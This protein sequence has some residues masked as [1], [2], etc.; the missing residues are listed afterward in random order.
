VRQRL[1]YID[2][3][4]AIGDLSKE[5]IY[6]DE[7]GKPIQSKGKGK[8]EPIGFK[9]H[10]EDLLRVL[11]YTQKDE[12]VANESDAIYDEKRKRREEAARKLEDMIVNLLSGGGG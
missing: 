11:G 3:R 2:D 6:Y 4:L 5:V 1:A 8:V 9:R 12:A 10:I 7:H